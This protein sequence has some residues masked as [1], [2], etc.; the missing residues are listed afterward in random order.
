MRGRGVIQGKLLVARLVGGPFVFG[1]SL[2]FLVALLASF[3]R[4][5]GIPLSAVPN[6]NGMLIT[7]PA[8]F[9]WM[10]VGFLL[11]NTVLRVIP[12]LRRISEASGPSFAEAQTQL[13]KA[14]AVGAI[15]CVPLIALGF[16]I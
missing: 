15:V 11:F 16:W 7:V 13:L 5:R 9:L 8:L 12:P 3:A 6:L 10:P 4:S 1:G 2:C 14:L